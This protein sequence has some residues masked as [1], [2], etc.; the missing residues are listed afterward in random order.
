MPRQ[1]PARPLV[2]ALLVAATIPTCAD[3]G[4]EAAMQADHDRKIRWQGVTSETCGVASIREISAILG[5]PVVDSRVMVRDSGRCH[6]L[7]RSTADPGVRIHGPEQA[8]ALDDESSEKHLPDLRAGVFLVPYQDDYRGHT[9]T[10]NRFVTVTPPD[11]APPKPS[12]DW[13][14]SELTADTSTMSQ[15]RPNRRFIQ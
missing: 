4:P 10:S 9:Y 13:S 12:C 14:W 11:R 2:I 15:S 7:S 8:P 6:R 1:L 5:T 3:R